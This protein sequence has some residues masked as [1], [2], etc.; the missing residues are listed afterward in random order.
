MGDRC[1]AYVYLSHVQE[2]DTTSPDSELF[3]FLSEDSTAECSVCYEDHPVRRLQ[4]F[5]CC[6]TL[7][8][9]ECVRE[10]VS[11]CD[12]RTECHP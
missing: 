5:Q 7:V 12:I 11:P 2:W 9:V 1:N 6:A 3:E 8:C 10:Q 4:R